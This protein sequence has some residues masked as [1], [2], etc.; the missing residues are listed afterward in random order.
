[1]FRYFQL[2]TI[3]LV[4][5]TLPIQGYSLLD[6]R[7]GMTPSKL[8]TA[9]L[10]LL[11]VLQ[12]VVTGRRPPPDDK[13][14]WIVIFILSFSLS[15]LVSIASGMSPATVVIAATT[16][17][18]LVLLYLTIA[19]VIR[20]P[21][22]LSLLLWSLLIGGAVTAA[23]AVLGLQVGGAGF[24]YGERFSGLAGQENLFGFDM[25]VCVPLGAALFFTSRTRLQRTVA[26]GL[27]TLCVA[28]LLLSLSRSAFVSLAVMG[29][30]WLWRSGRIENLGY[31]V[32]AVLLAAGIF[33][34]SPDA[35]KR[36]VETM[37]DP[38]QRAEDASI[39]S[40][41]AQFHWAARAIA[42]NPAV[43]V[44]VSRFVPW[45]R[46]QPGGAAFHHPIHNAYLAVAT[47]QGLLG[48]IP[49]VAILVL[50]WAH[51]SRVLRMVRARRGHRDRELRALAHH[52]N[53]LQIA[54]LG[55]LIGGMF[56]MAQNSK[57]LWL[58]LGLSPALLA[59]CRTRVGEL[60]AMAGAPEESESGPLPVLPGHGSSQPA[61]HSLPSPR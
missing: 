10:L 36:R 4:G 13:R 43:G 50:T 12:F 28:G 20:T 6:F 49:F 52:A 39:Q 16:P 54:L 27:T 26:L 24:D 53:F 14:V 9:V 18:A 1:M 29:A 2:F 38:G 59:L 58:L 5:F 61:R 42:S 45:V 57:T 37:T 32:P 30:F 51:Y 15:S 17:L 31:L 60:S 47:A 40:R 34:F 44:G 7:F 8:A 48:A 41:F 46:E 33:L 3:F 22:H 25:A 21:R 35:V 55:A 19:Y 11:A 23:P 56:H